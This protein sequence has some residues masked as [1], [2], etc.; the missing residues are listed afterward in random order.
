[1]NCWPILFGS[2]RVADTILAR[3]N[4]VRESFVHD[5]DSRRSGGISFRK[6]PALDDVNTN[7]ME[8]TGLDGVLERGFGV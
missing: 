3:P 8:I 7:G 4:F 5:G 2:E 6:F 1:L